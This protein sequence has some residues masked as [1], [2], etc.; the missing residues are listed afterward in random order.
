VPHRLLG[1]L[2][3]I[4]VAGEVKDFGRGNVAADGNRQIDSGHFRHDDT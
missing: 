4:D 1:Q 2:E 3:G